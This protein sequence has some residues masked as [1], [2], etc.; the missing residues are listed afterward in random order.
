MPIRDIAAQNASLAND[1][2]ASRGP[3]SAASHQLCLFAGDPNDGGTE[4][5]SAG[6]YARVTLTNDGTNWP[7]PANGEVT[8]VKA[9]FPQSTGA[10]SDDATHWALLGSD[11]LWWDT[12]ELESPISVTAAGVTKTIQPTIY[13][14]TRI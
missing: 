1:Y 13:Y 14:D 2:G 6:G 9:T 5:T 11:G 7:A 8:G 3:N 4:L 12:G 10:W